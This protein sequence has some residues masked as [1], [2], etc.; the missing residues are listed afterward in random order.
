MRTLDGLL[1]NHQLFLLSTMYSHLKE[2]TFFCRKKEE[3]YI[4]LEKYEIALTLHVAFASAAS[5]QGGLAVTNEIL[6][7]FVGVP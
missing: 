5:L 4:N 2:P 3:E 7:P 1:L 6:L